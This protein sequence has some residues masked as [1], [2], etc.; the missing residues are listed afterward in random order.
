MKNPDGISIYYS[1]NM[2]CDLFNELETMPQPLF[3]FLTMLQFTCAALEETPAER[4]D[5]VEDFLKLLEA[6][7][8]D[9]DTRNEHEERLKRIT[10][11][12]EEYLFDGDSLSDGEDW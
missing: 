4:K 8:P 7:T 5:R 12:F 3:N 11:Y 9:D 1:R 10:A 2:M 6:R